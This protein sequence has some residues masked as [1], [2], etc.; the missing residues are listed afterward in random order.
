MKKIS[1]TS[2]ETFSA[3]WMMP[4]ARRKDITDS[5]LL[6]SG[7]EVISANV[8]GYDIF[9]RVCGDVRVLFNDEVYKTPSGFPDELTELFRAHKA[10]HDPRVEIGLNNWYEIFVYDEKNNCILTDV[11][12]IDLH[13]MSPKDAK[14]LVLDTLAYAKEL[15]KG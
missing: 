5:M 10:D 3:F 4:K 2:K 8:G 14:A 13:D 9:V 11:V 6:D 15:A 12:D 7:T 1:K